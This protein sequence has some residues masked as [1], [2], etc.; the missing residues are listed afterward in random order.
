MNEKIYKR[1]EL[2]V[3]AEQYAKLKSNA[4]L[5]M[6]PLSKYMLKLSEEHPVYY[7]KDFAEICVQLKKMGANLNQIVKI[8]NAQKYANKEANTLLK[9]NLEK[10]TDITKLINKIALKVN[11]DTKYVA[12]EKEKLLIENLEKIKSD[13]INVI[14]NLKRGV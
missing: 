9:S 4:E 10:L 11:C 13:T 8:I 14:E 6:L 1:I 3:T 5:A 2:K 12:T 7:I